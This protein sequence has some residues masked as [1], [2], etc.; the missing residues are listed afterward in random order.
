MP[1][2]MALR[3]FIAC[4]LLAAQQTTA[5]PSAKPPQFTVEQFKQML[6]KLQQG[7]YVIYFR[8]AATDMFQLDDNPVMGNCASQRNLSDEGKEQAANIGKAFRK[9][10]IPVGTV[11]AS[12]YCRTTE[13]AKLAFDKAEL[14]DKLYFATRLSAAERKANAQYLL[15]LM[16]KQPPAGSNTV[17]VAHN[18]NL[19]E[20]FGIWPDEEGDAFVYKPDGKSPGKPI[21]QIP[22]GLWPVLAR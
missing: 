5:A 6:P 14:D 16:A 21:G 1:L 13:T 3:V 12:P 22:V 17:I 2:R 10:Q 19:M 8:H 15:D 4:A 7:G 11:K 9:L 20:A 18:A